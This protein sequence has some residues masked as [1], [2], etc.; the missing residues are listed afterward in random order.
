MK[1]PKDLHY[2]SAVEL[3]S[4]LANRKIS[5]VELLEQ[6]IARIEMLDKKINAMPVRDFERARAAAKAA[7]D[8]IAQGERKPLLGLPISVKESFNIAGLPTTWGDPQYKDWCPTEDALAVSRLKAA[9]AIIIGK[10][11]VPFMLADWQSYNDIYGTTNNPWDLNVTPG[12]SSGGSAAALA[13][14]FVSLELGSDLAGS[15]RAPAHYCGVFTHKPTQDLIPL[16]GAA[17]PATTPLP[18]GADLVTAGPLARTSEDLALALNVLAGPDEMLNGKGYQLTPPPPRHNHLSSFKVLVIDTH[19]LCPTAADI[20]KAMDDLVNHLTKVGVSVSRAV[21]KIPDL[22]KATQIYATFFAAFIGVNLPLS[23]YEKLKVHANK[24]RDDD[25]SLSACRLR[26]FTWTYRE[27][28]LATRKREALRKQWRDTFKEFDLI[29]CP[30]M[31]TPAFPHD[32]SNS[33]KRQI[34]IDDK[35]I[36]YYDQFIWVS[37]ATLFGL[38]A[39]VI[40]IAHSK[41]GLPIGI[42]VIGDYLEDY[43]TIKFA[44]LFEREFGGFAIPD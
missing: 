43:T 4:A 23:T 44:N 2:Q 30:V 3:I 10:T 11:N 34:K 36:P 40:P 26:G 41:N 21:N 25:N 38:P 13:A 37:I 24:L 15:L 22:A 12:G 7:D 16:R 39:T 33:E 9:G 31:P 35:L 8:A 1:N 27:W 28:F 5:S 19:P 32:H 29:L 18:M 14:G 17:P 42:Q 20:T 6:T